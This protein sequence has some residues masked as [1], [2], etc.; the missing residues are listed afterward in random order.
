MNIYRHTRIDGV[1]WYAMTDVLRALDYIPSGKIERATNYLA[2]KLDPSH[3]CKARFY[4]P[5]PRNP[6]L[7]SSQVLWAVNA[8]GKREIE[9][10]ASAYCALSFKM[11]GRAVRIAA[12]D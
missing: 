8:A 7:P 5:S 6:Q 2:D 4:R 10:R 3:L 1:K 11:A 12:A 9:R